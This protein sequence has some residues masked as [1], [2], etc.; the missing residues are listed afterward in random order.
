[1]LVYIPAPWSTWDMGLRQWYP[2]KNNIGLRNNILNHQ[3]RIVLINIIQHYSTLFNIFQATQRGNEPLA[4]WPIGYD[5]YVCKKQVH[6]SWFWVREFFSFREMSIKVFNNNLKKVH[7]SMPQNQHFQPKNNEYWIQWMKA[8][9][10]EWQSDHPIFLKKNG[11][12]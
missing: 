9:G 10:P 5:G 4:P 8:F 1:M 12:P 3:P 6:V 2:E 7:W 11:L